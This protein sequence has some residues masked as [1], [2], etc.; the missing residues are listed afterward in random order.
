MNFEHHISSTQQ[1]IRI[2][3][4]AEIDRLNKKAEDTTLDKDSRF[5]AVFERNFWKKE[6]GKTYVMG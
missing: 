1:A 6:L 2:Q 3:I 5:E 4:Q